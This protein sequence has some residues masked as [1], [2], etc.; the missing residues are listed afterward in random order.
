M[1]TNTRTWHGLTIPTAGTFVLDPAHTR[2]GFV[3]RHLVVSKVR[4]AFKDV[5]GEIVIAE[6][7]LD[8]SVNA[9]IQAVSIDTGVADRDN[10]LRTG[11]FLEAEKYPELSFRSTGLR[12][13][14]GENFI[15]VGD[16]TIKDVTKRVELELEFG[17]VQ[18]SP[19]GQEVI[20]F[21][22]TTE[23]DREDFNV[24]WN[25][26]LETGGMM[27]GKTLKIEIEGE[28]VRQA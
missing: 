2:V 16:L 18:K 9:V 25:Q 26:A 12:A 20:G 7:P 10:H 21:S 6:E 3:I 1:T 22:A 28:A 11:D 19:Y 8:S 14:S 24:T 17:G 13:V 4:G 27:L 23:I 15:L 5:A